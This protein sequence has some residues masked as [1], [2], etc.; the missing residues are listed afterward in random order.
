M[1]IV[2]CRDVLDRAGVTPPKPVEV[3]TRDMVEREIAR[4]E[5]ELGITDDAM[6]G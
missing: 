3:I 1:A 4:L 6:N 5:A 2:A